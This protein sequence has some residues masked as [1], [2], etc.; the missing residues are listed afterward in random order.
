[1]VSGPHLA[2]VESFILHCTRCEN[3]SADPSLRDMVAQFRH[4]DD[5]RLH[6]APT[7]QIENILLTNYLSY[8]YIY[9]YKYISLSLRE[10][11]LGVIA[12]TKLRLQ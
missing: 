6:Q 12:N 3:R 5:A 4:T 11:W 1:M 7:T 8:H 2:R 9:K 10:Y